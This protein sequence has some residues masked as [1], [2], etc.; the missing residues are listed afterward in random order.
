[1]TAASLVRRIDRLVAPATL[2]LRRERPALVSLLFHTLFRD[3]AE[4]QLGHVDPNQRTTV[5]FF[6]DFVARLVAAGYRFVTPAEVG[7]GLERG[8][9][10]ALLTFD[11]GY[12]NN[13]LALPILRRHGVPAVFFIST[14]HVRAARCFWWDVLYR[15]RRARGHVGARATGAE[16]ARLKRMK[17]ADVEAALAGEFGDAAFRPRGDVDRPMTPAE[18]RAFARE[19]LVHLGNHTRDHAILTNYPA[20]EARAQVAAAQDDLEEMAGV[21]PS[22]VAYP[23]GDY[24]DDVVRACRDAGLTLGLTINPRKAPLPVDPSGPCAMRLPRFTPEGSA[25]ARAEALACRSDVQVYDAL[26]GWFGRRGRQQR[27]D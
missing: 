6:D 23:N 19:P 24:S 3:A 4:M 17:A 9:R 27:G 2:A 26:R 11:D 13:T 22:A 10:Y 20:G 14:G 25:S 21:R 5:Q 8:G 1:M 7:A 16:V 12:F 15:E 18:L